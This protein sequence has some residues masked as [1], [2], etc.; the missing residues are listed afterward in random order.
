MKDSRERHQEALPNEAEFQAYYLMT[1]IDNVPNDAA[2]LPRDIYNSEPVQF[3]C[4]VHTGNQWSFFDFFFRNI[5]HSF[6]FL[7]VKKK[8]TN[9]SAIATDNYV[10][11]F[12]LVRR[13]DYLMACLMHLYFKRIRLKALRVLN[14]AC[15]K[16][17]GPYPLADLARQLLCNSLDE[18]LV[19]FFVFFFF[20]FFLKILFYSKL[21]IY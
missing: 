18:A 3:A 8:K 12:K 14:I 11:F 15:K 16:Q 20:F 21:K 19:F 2:T 6:S 9:Q 4:A 17:T 5:S 10:R 13:A 1:H 7:F